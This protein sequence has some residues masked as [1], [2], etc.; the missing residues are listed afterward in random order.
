MQSEV[1]VDGVANARRAL[2]DYLNQ[3]VFD[4]GNPDAEPIREALFARRD[5]ESVRRLHDRLLREADLWGPGAPEWRSLGASPDGLTT[6][7]GRLLQLHTEVQVDRAGCVRGTRV[8]L[9]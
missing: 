3:F 5:S 8:T 4:A 9:D 1:S 7:S 2:R 6:Y